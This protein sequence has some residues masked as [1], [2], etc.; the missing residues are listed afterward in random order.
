MNVSALA[1]EGGPV[2]PV[3]YSVVIRGPTEIRG[4]Y[5]DRRST[6]TAGTIVGIGGTL[7]GIVMLA[8]SGGHE[9]ACDNSGYCYRRATI[10]GNLVA[11]GIG[12]IL[13]SV[14]IG[15]V[16]HSQRDEA[17]ISVRPLTFGS[18]G[19]ARPVTFDF[20]VLTR[21]PQGGSLSMS[22]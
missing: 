4:I 21:L 22:F 12:V 6:R 14:I 10:D 20:P 3:Q 15:A 1:K 16:L 18:V 9:V 2:I 11:G 7:A 5:V 19:S 8:L 13:G 17:I